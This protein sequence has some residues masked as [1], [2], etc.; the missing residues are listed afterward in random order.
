MT[1]SLRIVVLVIV[2][3]LTNVTTAQGESLPESAYVSGVIGHAQGY[4]L[5]CESRSA[6]DW[7]AFWGVNIGETEFLLAL[8]HSA[9][10]DEGFVG[11]PNDVAGT[12]PPNSY[13]VHADPVADTLREFGLEAEAQ[14]DLSWYD[15]RYEI[16]AGRPVIVWVLGRMRSGTPVEYEAPDGSTTTVAYYEH[17]MILVGYNSD[18]V[19]VVDASSGLYEYYWLD[20]FLQSWAV[21]GN[22]AVFGSYEAPPDD[23]TLPDDAIGILYRQE[24]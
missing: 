20:T 1:H 3:L 22:M 14:H 4:S 10:P 13:G 12:I 11:D 19:Q 23:V 15:L 24:G 9:N 8:P 17:T 2:L 5:S 7:A 18:S 21:L 6:A 16:S